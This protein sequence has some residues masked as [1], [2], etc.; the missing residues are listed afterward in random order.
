MERCASPALCA[1]TCPGGEDPR[2]DR[3]PELR[4]KK[5]DDRVGS[6]AHRQS[7]NEIW[8]CVADSAYIEPDI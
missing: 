5:L 2:L 6:E 7:A 8:V 4:H 3:T 1:P